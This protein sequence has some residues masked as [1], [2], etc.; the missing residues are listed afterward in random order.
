MVAVKALAQ[1]RREQLTVA[2]GMFVA[3]ITQD[4][5]CVY[6][7]HKLVSMA[8]SRSTLRRGDFNLHVFNEV[9]PTIDKEPPTEPSAARAPGMARMLIAKLIL[10]NT[11]VARCQLTVLNSTP[12]TPTWKISCDSAFSVSLVGASLC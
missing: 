5:A 8:H 10:R 3:K 11:I 6:T 2:L 12:S 7:S 1:G 9:N 4:N